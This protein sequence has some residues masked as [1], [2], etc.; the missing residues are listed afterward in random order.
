[1]AMLDP[2]L[3]QVIISPAALVNVETADVAPVEGF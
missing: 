2:N 1:M 3:S